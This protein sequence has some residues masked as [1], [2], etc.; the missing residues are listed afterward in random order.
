MKSEKKPMTKGKL[1]F[2]SCIFF[3]GGMIIGNAFFIFLAVI[4]WIGI[5]LFSNNKNNS[6]SS[7]IQSGVTQNMPANDVRL[8]SA[9]SVNYKEHMVKES[10]D[11]CPICKKPAVN[12]YCKSCGYK[13]K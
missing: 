3:F 2:I 11:S 4:L 1:L 5:A 8:Q 7:E 10:A 6:N 12:G 13:F 9:E